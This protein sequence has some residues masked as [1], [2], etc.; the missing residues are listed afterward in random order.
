MMLIT[1]IWLIT[2]LKIFEASYYRL[3]YHLSLEAFACLEV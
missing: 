3:M 1:S 2:Y